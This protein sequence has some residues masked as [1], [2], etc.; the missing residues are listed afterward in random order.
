MEEI[1]INVAEGEDIS[2][3]FRL[4]KEAALWLEKRNIDYWK[5]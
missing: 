4:L 1:S 5:D 2:I 3:I